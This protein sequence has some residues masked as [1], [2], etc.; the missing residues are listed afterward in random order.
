MNIAASSHS[1]FQPIGGQTITS[2]IN[3]ERVDHTG[4]RKD[5]ER[6]IAFYHLLGF[7]VMTRVDF[8]PS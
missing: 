4:I 3:V 5:A 1:D 7:E 8:D 6:A 2:N